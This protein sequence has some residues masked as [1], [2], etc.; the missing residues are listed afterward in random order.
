[1]QTWQLSTIDQIIPVYA[2]GSDNN[3]VQAY[4]QAIKDA[5]T[6]WRRGQVQV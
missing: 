5:V 6:A 1:M 2:P 4:I 3:D